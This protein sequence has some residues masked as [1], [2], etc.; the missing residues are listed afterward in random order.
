MSQER[1]ACGAIYFFCVSCF[2]VFSFSI[3]SVALGSNICT[4]FLCFGSFFFFIFFLKVC[5][6]V[7]ACYK[8]NFFPGK[9]L[10]RIFPKAQQMNLMPLP[11]FFFLCFLSAFRPSE[12]A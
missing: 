3:F 10:H 1:D 7:Y 2:F 8:F 5:V 12:E 9:F 4:V 6:C 11:V